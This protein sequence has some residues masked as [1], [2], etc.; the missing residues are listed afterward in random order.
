MSSP[1]R[2]LSSFVA[3]LAGSDK[4]DHALIASEIE[5]LQAIY[6]EEAVQLWHPPEDRT[7]RRNSPFSDTIRYTVTLSLPYDGTPDEPITL[8]VL[9]SLPPTYPSSSPPQLQLLSKYVGNFGA[10]SALFG[11]ILRTYISVNGVDWSPDT[12]CAFDGLQNVIERCTSWYEERLSA[13]KASELLRMDAKEDKMVESKPSVSAR[14]GTEIGGQG[15][16][17]S[18]LDLTTGIEVFV[19]DPIVDRKSVF[20]GRACRLTDPTQVPYII[21]MLRADKR[22]ARAAHPTIWAYRCQ[23][24]STLYQDNDDDG[25]TAAGGRLGH[26]LQILELDDVLVIVTRYFGG[27]HLGPDRFK[28]IN[29]AARNALEVGG[30]LDSDSSDPKRRGRKH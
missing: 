16:A 17:S 15:D 27:I 10:D 6:G 24:G 23:V 8:R 19:A 21:S 4:P 13:D 18:A 9:V 14:P 26:L 28:H 25:E 11:A 7:A 12:V 22:I 2:Q 5:A 3:Q 20:V 30:F 29:N 1:P